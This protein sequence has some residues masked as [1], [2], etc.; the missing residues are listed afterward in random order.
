VII[1]S[2]SHQD[3]DW[4]YRKIEQRLII[5]KTR[6]PTVRKAVA[7]DLLS[8]LPIS[9]NLLENISMENLLPEKEYFAKLKVYTSKDLE[10]IDDEFINFFNALDVDQSIDYFIKAYRAYP[11]KIRFDLLEVEET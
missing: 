7:L 3:T 5:I 1:V 10:G 9:L 11:N 6:N 2:A 4:N 8:N